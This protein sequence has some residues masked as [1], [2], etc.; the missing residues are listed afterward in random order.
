MYETV[1][2]SGLAGI[3]HTQQHSVQVSSKP[4]TYTCLDMSPLNLSQASTRTKRYCSLSTTQSPTIKADSPTHGELAIHALSLYVYFVLFVFRLHN[5]YLCL[6]LSLKNAKNIIELSSCLSCRNV[7]KTY[8]LTYI[9][10]ACVVCGECRG[11]HTKYT[12][13]RG[14]VTTKVSNCCRVF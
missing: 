8:L 9:C 6:V 4:T 5:V 14:H 11:Y 12:S 10:M 13:K 3:Q 7:T 1:L 2:R